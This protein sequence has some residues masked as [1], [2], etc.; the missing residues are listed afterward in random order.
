MISWD[1]P[2]IMSWLL[3]S[4]LG[5]YINFGCKISKTGFKKD[6]YVKTPIIFYIAIGGGGGGGNGVDGPDGGTGPFGSILYNHL[7]FAMNPP[8]CCSSRSLPEQENQKSM[9]TTANSSSF[10]RFLSLPAIARA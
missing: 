2:M 7:P 8:A 4:I 6:Y 9:S 3:C 5:H 1:Y 10:W